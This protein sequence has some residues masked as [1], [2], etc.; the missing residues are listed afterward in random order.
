MM[1]VDG[2]E[3]PM[4]AQLGI[5]ILARRWREDGR[6]ARLAQLHHR[7]A[8]RS[9]LVQRHYSDDSAASV[10]CF[11]RGRYFRSTGPFMIEA[12]RQA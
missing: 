12:A 1:T 3:K 11:I 9:V 5:R 7:R 4:T 10:V 8:R 2:G 6:T